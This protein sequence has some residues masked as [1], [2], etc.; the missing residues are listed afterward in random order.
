MCAAAYSEE[1][2]FNTK[3]IDKSWLLPELTGP[4][5]MGLQ[6]VKGERRRA[7]ANFALQWKPNKDVEL[8]A[9]GLAPTTWVTS[10]PTSWSR[11]HGGYLADHV[12]HQDSGHQPVARSL[13]SHDVNTIMSTQANRASNV[14]QQHAIG[15]RWNA[16]P[17]LKLTT[18]LART[19]SDYDWQNPILDTLTVMPTSVVNTNIGGSANVAYSGQDITDSKNYRLDQLFDRYGHDSGSSTDWRADGTYT[20]A[21]DGLFKDFGFGVRAANAPPHRSSPSKARRWRPAPCP[22]PACLA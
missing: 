7:A 3:P 21:E 8:Y 11:C 2:A 4:D 12:R 6:N 14:T 15:G 18:E 17:G 10:R 1:R 5:L 22:P 9:E 16:A 13:T 20:L 19:L